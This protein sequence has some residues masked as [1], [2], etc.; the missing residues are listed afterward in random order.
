MKNHFIFL[1]LGIASWTL[2]H[3]QNVPPKP[4]IQQTNITRAPVQYDHLRESDVMWSK[5]VWRKLD[6]REKINHQFYFPIEEIRDRRSLIQVLIQSVN[7]GSLTA[8]DPIG[9]EF[10]RILTSLEVDQKLTRVD[11]FLVPRDEPPYDLI[12]MVSIEPFD[13]ARVKEIRIME[14]WFFDKQRGVMEVRIIGIQPVADNIDPET[15]EV[16]GKEPMFWVYFPEARNIFAS[17]DVFNR[18]N[19]AQRWTLD[20]VFWKRMFG[21]YIYKEQNVYDRQIADYTL[22][23]LEQLLE[24]ERVKDDIFAMEHDLWEY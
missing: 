7:E 17:E 24:A 22:N 10:S 18:F 1:V 9:S 11:T 15:G 19:D 16:R 3:S 12:P 20:D 13:Y 23:G 8:Y 2:A 21:S 14:D 5:R 4:Y 6:L